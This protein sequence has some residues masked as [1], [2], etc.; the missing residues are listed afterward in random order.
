MFSL[1]TMFFDKSWTDIK[2]TTFQVKFVSISLQ[3][4]MAI[5]F[6]VGLAGFLTMGT[7]L[8]DG[9]IVSHAVSLGRPDIYHEWFSEAGLFLGS[10]QNSEKIVR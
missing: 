1:K 3:L 8:W 7:D 4:L 9:V 5:T 6:T 10:P 2:E